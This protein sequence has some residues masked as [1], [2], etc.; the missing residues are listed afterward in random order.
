MKLYFNTETNR[1]FIAETSTEGVELISREHF[2]VAF[3]S[4]YTGRSLDY[5]YLETIYYKVLTA[6]AEANC[7]TTIAEIGFDTTVESECIAYSEQHPE[8]NWNYSIIRHNNYLRQ[9]TD[10]FV[11]G[12]VIHEIAHTVVNEQLGYGN[13]LT[14]RRRNGE[15][16]DQLF[17]DTVNKVQ[18][19][20]KLNGFEKAYVKTEKYLKIN[21]HKKKK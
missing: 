18:F 12:I 4:I 3:K 15:S 6:Y 13:I 21:Q 7:A 14:F 5:K 11:Y 10:Q 20:F 19:K 9:Y 17:V 2:N 16:H 8:L 1:I